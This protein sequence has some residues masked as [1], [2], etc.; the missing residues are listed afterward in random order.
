MT[1]LNRGGMLGGGISNKDVPDA[2]TPPDG[3]WNVTGSVAASAAITAG[4][5]L[6]VTGVASFAVGTVGAPG[7]AF[8]A[9]PTTGFYSDAEGYID[10]V[11]Y[12]ASKAQLGYYGLY[13]K[14]FLASSNTSAGFNTDAAYNLEFRFANKASTPT[15]GIKSSVQ[16]NDVSAAK[17]AVSTGIY[18]NLTTS[19]TNTQNHS[20]A[21]GWRVFE[22]EATTHASST[23]VV[24]GIVNYHVANGTFSGATVTNQYGFYCEALSGA[25]TLNIPLE[26]VSCMRG[27]YSA[28]AGDTRLLVYDVDNATLERV[29][30]G[31]ADSGG[32]GYKLLRIAN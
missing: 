8:T 31:I 25:G 7:I 2:Y 4:T 24:T 9:Y 27:D 14:N 30:V 29:T 16:M 13:S 32:A 1:W 12:G 19:T 10:V 17:T 18:S 11:S 5:T 20:A 3:T 6:G 22:S 15:W 26:L 23:G 21:L 28:T